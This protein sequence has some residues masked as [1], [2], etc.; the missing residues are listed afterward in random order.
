MNKIYLFFVWLNLVLFFI[1]ISRGL[2]FTLSAIFCIYVLVDSRRLRKG[3]IS[4]F[5]WL[6]LFLSFCIISCMW[7]IKRNVAMWVIVMQQFP[8]YCFCMSVYLKIKNIDDFKKILRAFFYATLA[9]LVFVVVNVD[10]S[11]IESSRLASSED[12]ED[13]LWNPNYLG[14][15]FSL[16]CYAGY[17][18]IF[19]EKRTDTAFS[20]IFITDSLSE[21]LNL[22]EGKTYS[23][24]TGILKSTLL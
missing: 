6:L 20:N 23:C 10:V 3:N 15:Y 11:Q 21:S 13:A 14:L 12:P 24:I 18:S 16:G 22:A 17:F 19:R 9:L 8:I 7:A 5:A 1:N 2:V 4:Y